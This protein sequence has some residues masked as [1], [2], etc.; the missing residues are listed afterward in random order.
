MRARE[1]ERLAYFVTRPRVIT[2]PAREAVEFCFS[3]RLIEVGKLNPRSRRREGLVIITAAEEK[4]PGGPV[5]G[6]RFPIPLFI[7]HRSYLG[8]L[9][10]PIRLAEAHVVELYT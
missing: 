6:T 3:I 10:P 9:C 4:V 7:T 5:E 1:A 2:Y 8:V